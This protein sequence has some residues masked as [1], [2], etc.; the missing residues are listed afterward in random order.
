MHLSEQARPL[1]LLSL[2]HWLLI[3]PYALVFHEGQVQQALLPDGR[4]GFVS[5]LELLMILVPELV[6]KRQRVN[7]ILI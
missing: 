2:L 6:Q 5:V 1:M 7:V 4:P 3:H